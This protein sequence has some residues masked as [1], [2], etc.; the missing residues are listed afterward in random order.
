MVDVHVLDNSAETIDDKLLT[1]E[2]LT[3]SYKFKYYVVYLFICFYYYLK[4]KKFW[5]SP[6]MSSLEFPIFFEDPVLEVILWTLL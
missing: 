1:C 3:L 2:K 5:K 4:K 6:I